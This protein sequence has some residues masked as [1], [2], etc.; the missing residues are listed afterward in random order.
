MLYTVITNS[1]TCFVNLFLYFI[2]MSLLYIKITLRYSIR[3]TFITIFS[4]VFQLF[5]DPFSGTR[6]QKSFTHISIGVSH[7][8]RPAHTAGFFIPYDC[9]HG[10]WQEVILSRIVPIYKVGCSN[11]TWWP[12]RKDYSYSCYVTRNDSKHV[13]FLW[14]VNSSETLHTIL[15]HG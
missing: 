5:P 13:T 12:N 7:V 6:Q 11:V 10:N 4:N 8:A 2:T 15:P 3:H 1:F 9:I 14:P